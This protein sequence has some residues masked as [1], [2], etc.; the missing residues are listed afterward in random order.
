MATYHTLFRSQR[1]AI[2]ERLIEL[3]DLVYEIINDTTDFESIQK[4]SSRLTF[5]HD[6]LLSLQKKLTKIENELL[7]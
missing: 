2:T 4:A 1:P 7:T 6:E 3:Q 5:I